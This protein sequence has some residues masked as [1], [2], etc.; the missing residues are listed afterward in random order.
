MEA[1]IKFTNERS[2]DDD[3]K[4]EV[5]VKPLLCPLLIC[6]SYQN[7]HIRHSFLYS[8]GGLAM[9]MHDWSHLPCCYSAAQLICV[10]DPLLDKLFSIDCVTVSSHAKTP[11]PDCLESYAGTLI[12]SDSTLPQI[13]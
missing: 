10:A 12:R 5:G 4:E 13:A 6:A 3:K 1:S 8:F 2:F 11:T 7:V 9:N